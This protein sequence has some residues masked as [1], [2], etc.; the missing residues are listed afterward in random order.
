M[1]DAAHDEERWSSSVLKS[2]GNN[3]SIASV[4][5]KVKEGE[6]DKTAKSFNVGTNE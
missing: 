5:E 1:I 3:I 6:E 4:S 2:I